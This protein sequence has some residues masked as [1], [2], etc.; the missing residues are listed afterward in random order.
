MKLFIMFVKSIGTPSHII[1]MVIC[2]GNMPCLFV[3]EFAAA[4]YRE[5]L[6]WLFV[7]EICRSYLP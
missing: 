1:A 6:P 7:V 5:N 3:V 2:A 4:I